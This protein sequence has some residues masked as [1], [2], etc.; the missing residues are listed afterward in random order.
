MIGHVG[1]C[2]TIQRCGSPCERLCGFASQ[3]P[4]C[5]AARRRPLMVFD[6]SLDGRNCPMR[7]GV[8]NRRPRHPAPYAGVAEI[9][10]PRDAA[11]RGRAGRPQVFPR[12]VSCLRRQDG[13][14]DVSVMRCCGSLLSRGLHCKD[15]RMIG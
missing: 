1:S 3:W 11:A 2:P 9:G 7:G 6:D 12:R 5:E 15:L 10:R 4:V 8:P 14:A 13:A